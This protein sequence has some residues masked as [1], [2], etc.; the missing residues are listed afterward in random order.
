MG[1]VNGIQ[2]HL[3]R[4]KKEKIC[5]IWKK[6]TV[7]VDEAV[8][9]T[10]ISKGYLRRIAYSNPEMTIQIGNPRERHPKVRFKRIKLE[11]YILDELSELKDEDL[12]DTN[13]QG[14]DEHEE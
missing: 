3:V 9:L 10:G 12:A 13:I 14:G 1:E 6:T 5:P 8:D 4:T 11:K 7:T 2:N